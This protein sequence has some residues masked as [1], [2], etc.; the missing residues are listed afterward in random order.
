MGK[1]GRFRENGLWRVL[2]PILAPFGTCTLSMRELVPHP[3]A[4]R[5]EAT[6]Y[7]ANN[8]VIG[9]ATGATTWACEAWARSYVEAYDMAAGA[10]LRKV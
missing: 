3:A 1:I 8:V 6:L 4:A 9:S 10:V 7:D 2:T 5:Y